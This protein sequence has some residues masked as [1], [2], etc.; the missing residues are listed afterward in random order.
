MGR[1]RTSD[2]R[3]WELAAPTIDPTISWLLPRSTAIGWLSEEDTM[4][5]RHLWWGPPAPTFWD[6]WLAQHSCMK[7]SK[8]VNEIFM[9]YQRQQEKELFSQAVFFYLL[10][11]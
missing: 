8:P 4:S 1:T 5:L 2:P 9:D 10:F 11:Y 6:H 7:T 3:T